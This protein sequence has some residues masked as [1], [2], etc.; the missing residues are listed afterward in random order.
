VRTLDGIDE[1]GMYCFDLV[2]VDSITLVFISFDYC[3][4]YLFYV[5]IY[6]KLKIFW[7]KVRI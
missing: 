2:S 4:C 3:H 7:N 6:S 1:H 5:F